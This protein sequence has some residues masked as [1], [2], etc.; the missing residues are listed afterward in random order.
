MTTTLVNLRCFLNEFPIPRCSIE[1]LEP[2]ALRAP[3]GYGEVDIVS[4]VHEQTIAAQSLYLGP[5]KGLHRPMEMQFRLVDDDDAVFGRGTKHGAFLHTL[6]MTTFS[7]SSY[8][9][10]TPDRQLGLGTL[11]R[12]GRNLL[13]TVF[14]LRYDA[15]QKLPTRSAGALSFIDP[16]VSI[17]VDFVVFGHR[18]QAVQFVGAAAILVAAAA[19]NL[20]WSLKDSKPPII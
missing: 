8:P 15:I 10:Q 17:V 16:L 11:S 3:L 1:R 7:A 2:N 6:A 19:L 4:Q 20:G 18:L 13:R 9:F 14:V 5:Q 12:H